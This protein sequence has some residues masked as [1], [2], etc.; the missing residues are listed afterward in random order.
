MSFLSLQS[1]CLLT[2]RHRMFAMFADFLMNAPPRVEGYTMRVSAPVFSKARRF[3]S[4]LEGRQQLPPRR[5]LL[6]LFRQPPRRMRSDVASCR[7][8]G[9][10]K[11]AVEP[12][13][14]P[15]VYW[16]SPVLGHEVS[17]TIFGFRSKPWILPS[18]PLLFPFASNEKASTLGGLMG[19][20]LAELFSQ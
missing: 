16:S 19:E 13:A 11:I 17:S 10:N 15:G 9:P 3:W 8:W 5:L 12:Q 18:H 14:S 6:L 2:R 7:R 4:A 20:F 1:R